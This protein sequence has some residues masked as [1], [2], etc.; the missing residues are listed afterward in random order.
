MV[1]VWK[2]WDNRLKKRYVKPDGADFFLI[3]GEPFRELPF[4]DIKFHDLLDQF[5]PVPFLF[6]LV[7]PQDEL[8]ETREMQRVH[9][10]RFAR[11]YQIRRGAVDEDELEKLEGPALD[12]GYVW[13]NQNEAISPIMDAP[14]DRAVAMNVP[15]TK[16]DFIQISATGG[17]A[18]GSAEADT[19][20]QASIIDTHLRVRDSF[21]RQVVAEYLSKVIRLI[22][23]TARD[24]MTLP[25]YMKTM[26]DPTGMNAAQEAQMVGQTWQMV[27]A[28]DIG[29]FDFEV[30]IE[31][32][33]LAPESEDKRRDQWNTVLS[34]IGSPNL[35]LIFLAS[36]TILRKTLRFYGVVAD[37]EIQDI[38]QA[39]EMQMQMQMMQMMATSG[40]PGKGKDSGPGA[41]P[42]TQAKNAAAAR[43]EP[44]R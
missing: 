34:M 42:G 12:G 40:P 30:E 33:S 15:T 22:V 21:A 23:L 36:D 5:Y 10:R 35:Q 17:E 1:K 27:K 7:S 38:K 41:D 3:D 25:W 16:E 14:L 32:E 2:I 37:R 8:N 4:A 28:T 9:R 6:N 43:A 24:N 13:V 26:V 20:T 44:G 18:R 11:R 31:V 29:D 19:A 39:I